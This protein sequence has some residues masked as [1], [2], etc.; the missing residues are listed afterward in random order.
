MF[1]K[2]I[3][4]FFVECII[5]ATLFNVMVNDFLGHL[6]RKLI[7]LCMRMIKLFKWTS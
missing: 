7:S 3:L 6:I 2:F 4:E 5:S 1:R